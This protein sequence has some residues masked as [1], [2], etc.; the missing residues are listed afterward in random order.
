MR[1]SLLRLAVATALVVTM[2]TAFTG[3]ATAADAKTD[4]AL[5][6][7]WAVNCPCVSCDCTP[8]KNCGSANCPAVLAAKT[9]NAAPQ[10]IGY[11]EVQVC[12]GGTCKLVRV[13]VY[14]T[15]PT[16]QKSEPVVLQAGYSYPTA[17]GVPC[18]SG[19]CGSGLTT[20]Q[21]SYNAGSFGATAGACSSGSSGERKGFF[22]RIQE[23]REN[24]GGFFGGRGGCSSCR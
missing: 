21:G 23:R 8:A 11:R 7:A 17:A 14:G 13:P 16:A 2:F 24:R 20:V 10:V 15:A 6:W 3:T 18:A 9:A 4:P 12:E 19:N 5:A 22:A 1:L